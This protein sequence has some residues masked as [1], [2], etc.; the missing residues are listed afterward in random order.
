MHLDA[1]AYVQVP[2]HQHLAHGLQSRTCMEHATA[3]CR[4]LPVSAAT[5]GDDE[6]ELSDMIDPAAQAGDRLR[7][8]MPEIAFFFPPPW[9]R[10]P[11][12]AD[13]P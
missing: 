8:K 5:N 1:R 3:P 9:D 11:M 2:V 10:D 6:H 7:K 12:V 4:T 13:S